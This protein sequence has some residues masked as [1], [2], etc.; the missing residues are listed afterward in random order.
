MFG[1]FLRSIFGN[2]STQ[3]GLLDSLQRW[4]ATIEYLNI[5]SRL[6]VGEE[7]QYLKDGFLRQLLMIVVLKSGGGCKF[8]RSC[9]TVAHNVVGNNDDEDKVIIIIIMGRKRKHVD[10]MV[11][12]IE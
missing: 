3:L 12:I 9:R 10:E 1:R 4:L 6:M 5:S 11:A 7:V 2:D 8:L